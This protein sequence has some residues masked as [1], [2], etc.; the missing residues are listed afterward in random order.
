MFFVLT[1]VCSVIGIVFYSIAVHCAKKQTTFEDFE[2]GAF[3]A[4]ILAIAFHLLSGQ[5][6]NAKSHW[7]LWNT[8]IKVTAAITNGNNVVVT[9]IIP[10]GKINLYSFPKNEVESLE[11]GKYHTVAGKNI[12][13]KPTLV[14]SE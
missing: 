8:N 12:L 6:G 14:V 4:V 3:I 10:N 2:T 13:A 1:I 9:V 5:D 11:V 7:R